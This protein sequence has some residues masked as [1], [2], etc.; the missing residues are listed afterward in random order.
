MNAERL[1]RLI[2]VYGASPRRWPDDERAAAERLLAERADL[3]VALQAAADLDHWLD[4]APNPRPSMALHDRVLA[5]AIQAGRGRSSVFGLSRPL[6]W[7]AGAGLA[8]ATCAGALSGMALTTHMTADA[9]AEAVYAQASFGVIDD[10][11]VLG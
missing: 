2:E 7:L 10:A 5:S 9:R 3:R 1:E 6:A 4:A 11:E 8:A